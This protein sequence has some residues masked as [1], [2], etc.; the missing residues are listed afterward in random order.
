MPLIHYFLL[1][2]CIYDIEKLIILFNWFPFYIV[3]FFSIFLKMKFTCL[4]M[5]AINY[6]GME[7]NSVLDYS[8]NTNLNVLKTLISFKWWC[9]IC[10]PNCSNLIDWEEACFFWLQTGGSVVKVNLNP[11]FVAYQLCGLGIL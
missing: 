6:H 1:S 10:F 3:I 2:F 11:E 7:V 8:R 5:F 4:V 9:I